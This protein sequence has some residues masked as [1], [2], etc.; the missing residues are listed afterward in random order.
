MRWVRRSDAN[1][2]YGSEGS[3]I[4][5]FAMTRILCI[6][7]TIFIRIQSSAESWLIHA[8]IVTVPRFLDSNWIPGPQRLKPG[9]WLGPQSARVELVP[10]PGRTCRVSILP[11]P[12]RYQAH[13]HR[14]ELKFRLI[15]IR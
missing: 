7:K 15:R 2:K 3:Q 6:I 11:R 4:I 5:G 8:S 9:C 12:R 10:F 13:V 14:L 1:V